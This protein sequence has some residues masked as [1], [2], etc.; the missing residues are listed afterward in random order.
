MVVNPQV[1]NAPDV[2]EVFEATGVLLTDPITVT[3]GITIEAIVTLGI[4]I[5]ATVIDGIIIKPTVIVGI[6]DIVTE[7]ILVINVLRVIEDAAKLVNVQF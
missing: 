3:V 5:E 2:T 7:G 1:V 4:T 6:Y